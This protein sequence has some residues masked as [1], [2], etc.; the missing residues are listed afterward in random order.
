MWNILNL[1]NK[2]N[3]PTS[4]D[5]YLFHL[6]S[7]AF[8]GL[9]PAHMELPR[10]GVKS[11]LHLPAYTTATATSDPSCGCDLHHS[12]WQCRILNP[13]SEARDWTCI[14]MVTSWVCYHWTT[15]GNSNLGFLAKLSSWHLVKKDIAPKAE[16]YFK[17]KGKGTLDFCAEALPTAARP[18]LKT[19]TLR[20]P[21]MP[22]RKQTSQRRIFLSFFLSF[23]KLLSVCF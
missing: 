11:E 22:L 9:H 23:C 13:L 21:R 18:G 16:I 19:L 3:Y 1:S 20:E 7:F 10:L 8:L 6:F 15:N 5:F 4:L 14:L 17:T 12:S 2:Q